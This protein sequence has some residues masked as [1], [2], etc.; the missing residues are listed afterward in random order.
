MKEGQAGRRV[1][2]KTKTFFSQR[3]KTLLSLVRYTHLERETANSPPPS[4]FIIYVL[5]KTEQSI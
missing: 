5:N 2:V 3:S 1:Q 4:C